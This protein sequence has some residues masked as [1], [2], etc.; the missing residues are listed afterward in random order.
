M[1]CLFTSDDGT[2]KN[3][4]KELFLAR[5]DG[6]VWSDNEDIKNTSVISKNEI[7]E[8]WNVWKSKNKTGVDC[9]VSLSLLNDKVILKMENSGLQVV[10][11]TKLP[12]NLGKVYFYITGD[13]CAITQ[14]KIL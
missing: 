9:K 6:E 10:N 13:Q 12:E 1:I 14:I 4:Y 8:N 5:M 2:L 3:N 7:F 11:Q